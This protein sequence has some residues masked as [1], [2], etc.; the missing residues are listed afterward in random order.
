MDNVD[1]LHPPL[2]P[3]TRR[4]LVTRLRLLAIEMDA[5]TKLLY[6]INQPYKAAV[7]VNTSTQ[8]KRWSESKDGQNEISSTEQKA[9][10]L[11]GNIHIAY[12]G[13]DDDNHRFHG[14]ISGNWV[15]G[16]RGPGY[17]LDY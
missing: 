17:D 15:S 13:L 2:V 8:I 7:L 11:V 14:T 3:A 9:Q 12:P 1:E 6:E 16:K 5:V 4:K 10:A